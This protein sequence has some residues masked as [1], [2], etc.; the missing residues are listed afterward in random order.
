MPDGMVFELSV[1]PGMVAAAVLLASCAA[2]IKMVVL[3][4][5]L[6]IERLGS[7][8]VPAKIGAVR[9]NKAKSLIEA[10]GKLSFFIVVVSPRKNL[11]FIA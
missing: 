9:A 8:I 10:P 7:V 5:E 3:F 6:E 2:E 11:S 4:G 1:R